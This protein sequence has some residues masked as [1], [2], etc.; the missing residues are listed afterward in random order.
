V[1][2]VVSPGGLV[3]LWERLV[4]LFSGTRRDPLE[5]GPAEPSV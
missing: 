1:I 4:N 3:G 5:L 2:V